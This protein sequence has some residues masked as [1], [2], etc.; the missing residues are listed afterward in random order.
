MVDIMTQGF[1]STSAAVLFL[2]IASPQIVACGARSDFSYIT[3]GSGGIGS[4]P[5]TSLGGKGGSAPAG[6]GGQVTGGTSNPGTNLVTTC[7][8]YKN[9]TIGSYIV[10]T[11]YW[12][13]TGCPGTQCMTVDASTGSF[14]VTQGPNCGDTVASY[15]NVLYGSSFGA[16]SPGSG[17]PRQMSS[18]TSVTSSWVFSVGG[19]SAD[20][21]DVAYDIWFCPNNSCGSGGF[22][23]GLE[24]MIWVNYQNTYGWQYDL[25]AVNL[26]GYNWEVWTFAQG[27][28]SNTWTYLAYLIQPSMVT[29]VTNLDLLSF[30]RDAEARGYLQ[31]SWYL[32]AVQAG[33]ELRSGGLPYSSYNFSVSVN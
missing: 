14:T 2:G 7:D 5:S 30:F 33:N 32:Y 19:T 8:Q 22:P 12:N 25:G 17:L 6:S 15:P 11:D 31:N 27:G 24:L 13:Q 20:H 26:S 4:I 23:G 10:E 3:G 18:L 28:G 29:S 21:Y 9:V 1:V 16:I